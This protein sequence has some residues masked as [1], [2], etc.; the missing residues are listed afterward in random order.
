MIFEERLKKAIHEV[1]DFPEPGI[2]FKDITGI[3]HD[4][5]LVRECVQRLAAPF[6]KDNI[7]KIIGIE[8]RGF[9][10]GPMIAQA[11]N[12]SFVTVRKKGKLPR[13]TLHVNY[14]LEYGNAT[15]EAHQDAIVV[16][17]RVLIHD[18]LLATGGTA[19]AAAQLTKLM[20]GQVV[21]FCFIIQLLHL[22][23][24]AKLQSFSPKIISLIDY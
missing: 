8:S 1:P 19:A 10:M 2:I 5:E 18:D 22:G 3:W 23:G 12:C 21:G 17:D 9:L 7:H 6:E 20:G 4:P 11:L 14:E 24:A 15:I 16:G 13:E